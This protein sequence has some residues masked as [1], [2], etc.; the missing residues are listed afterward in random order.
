ME[1]DSD[2]IGQIVQWTIWG[3]LMAVIMGWLGSQRTRP[4]T[5]TPP[6]HLRHPA[7]VLAI[8]VVCATFFV[9]LAVASIAFDNGTG[10]WGVASA[11]LSFALAGG[12]MILEYCRVRHNCSSNGLTYA[13]LF[14][15]GGFI[16]WH[17]V[18]S[19]RYSESMKWFRITATTGEIARVSAM[20]KGLPCFA[21]LVLR[22]VHSP[23]IDDDTRAVLQQ[24]ADGNPPSIW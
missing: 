10:G 13:R 8:G 18:S 19:I 24:T 23:A 16:G 7:G 5:E 3:I 17:N 2:T 4:D 11:F 6:G 15:K 21:D 14:G 22:H 20:L 12:L 1:M 9:A